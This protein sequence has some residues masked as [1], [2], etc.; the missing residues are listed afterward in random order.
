MKVV[1]NFYD[2]LKQGENKPIKTFNFEMSVDEIEFFIKKV[3]EKAEEVF[4]EGKNEYP[5][6]YFS[7]SFVISPNGEMIYEIDLLNVMAKE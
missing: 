5:Y 3:T 2:E 6:Q 7:S 1:V 4:L